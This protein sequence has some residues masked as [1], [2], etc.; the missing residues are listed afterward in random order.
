MVAAPH[1]QRTTDEQ[2]G[3]L[4]RVVM[5]FYAYHPVPTNAAALGD[6]RFIRCQ[7]LAAHAVLAPSEREGDLAAND[8][9][10]KSMASQAAHHTPMAWQTLRRQTP[11]VGARCGDAASRDLC[12]GRVVTHVPTAIESRRATKGHGALPCCTIGN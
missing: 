11:K 12:G 5:G 8:R 10:A 6:F 3:R 1:M 7:Y 2:G 4:R 9:A